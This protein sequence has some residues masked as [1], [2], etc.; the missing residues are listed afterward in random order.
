MELKYGTL[1]MQFKSSNEKETF[2][3]LKLQCSGART[4]D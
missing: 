1:L 4:E 2:S 3:A